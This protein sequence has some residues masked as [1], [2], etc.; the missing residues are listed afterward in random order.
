VGL[1]CADTAS[2]VMTAVDTAA[3]VGR[4]RASG[5]HERSAHRHLAVPAIPLCSSAGKFPVALRCPKCGND[6]SEG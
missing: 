4:R 1:E 2:D 6:V 3:H 5:L